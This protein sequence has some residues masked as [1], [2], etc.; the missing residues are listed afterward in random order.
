MLEAKIRYQVACEEKAHRLVLQLLEPG[1]T[2]D[3]LVNAGLYLTPNHYQDITEERA[4]SRIC[5]YPVCVNQI[6]K[7]LNQKYHIS[8]KTNRVYDITDRKNFCSN[9]CYKAS[10]YYQKQISSSPLWSRKEEKPKPIDLLPKE[11][12]RGAMGK[13]VINQQTEMYREAKWLR[14]EEKKDQSPK[15]K[16]IEKEIGTVETEGKERSM[17]KGDKNIDDLDLDVQKL[18]LHEKQNGE[19]CLDE[20]NKT[21]NSVEKAKKNTTRRK[22]ERTVIS[23]VTSTSGDKQSEKIDRL[24]ALLDRRKHLIGK[25]VQDERTVTEAPSKPEKELSDEDTAGE[26]DQPCPQ[27][28]AH[29]EYEENVIIQSKVAEISEKKFTPPVCVPEV[30]KRRKSREKLSNVEMSYLRM[31]CEILKEWITPETVRF[32]RSQSE[33]EEGPSSSRT[34][35]EAKLRE[36]CRR[37]DHQESAL[38]D[39]IGEEDSLEDQ[40]PPRSPAPN[41]ESLKKDTQEFTRRVQ[42]FFAAGK[43]IKEKKPDT[44]GPVYLPSV[45]TYDQMLI[46]QRIVME[47]LNKVIPDLLPPLKLTI[48]DVFAEMKELV[49]T[50]RLTSSNIVFKPVEWSL[51]GLILLKILSQRN[52]HVSCAF[53]NTSAVQYFSV[54]LDGIKETLDNVDLYVT[55]LLLQHNKVN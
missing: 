39:L 28:E 32:V 42:D 4:I 37:V 52:L 27:N 8:T 48:Q 23:S 30:S 54:F 16:T 22:H 25:L 33:E 10:A 43:V 31:V 9:E 26:R 18:N 24:M 5:G 36:I 12:N 38:D 11:M 29:S 47:Q 53:L 41:Y 44:Q 3:E 35:M 13:E 45:D 1:I 6:T 49:M 46:R 7:S 40:L 51:V 2:E 21:R 17:V 34:E 50:F 55:S 20:K 19:M 14:E 15:E